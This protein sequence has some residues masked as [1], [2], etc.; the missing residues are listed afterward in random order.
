MNNVKL[1]KITKFAMNHCFNYR[2]KQSMPNSFSMRSCCYKPFLATVQLRIWSWAMTIQ[3]DNCDGWIGK[4]CQDPKRQSIMTDWSAVSAVWS[5]TTKWWI[6]TPTWMLVSRIRS[7]NTAALHAIPILAWTAQPA[8]STG[9][10]TSASAVTLLLISDET[11]KPVPLT[12]SKQFMWVFVWT[13]LTITHNIYT[14]SRHMLIER[15]QV[16]HAY[17][18]LVSNQFLLNTI[19]WLSNLTCNDIWCCSLKSFLGVQRNVFSLSLNLI[20]VCHL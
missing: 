11:A 20:K 17:M 4:S 6:C 3:F 15:N 18:Q 9:A 7:G 10:L 16:T 1:K 5:W 8:S 19:F 2:N 14:Q 13:I 12:F